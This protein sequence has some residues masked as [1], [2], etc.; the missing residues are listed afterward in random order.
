MMIASPSYVQMA[1]MEKKQMH[2]VEEHG[3]WKQ[4]STD[5]FT[6]QVGL[7]KAEQQRRQ[8]YQPRFC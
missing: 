6:G 4:Y 8:L 2:L 3:M 1:D 7:A 5:G